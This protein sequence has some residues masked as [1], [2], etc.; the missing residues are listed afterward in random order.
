MHKQ[1]RTLL[2]FAAAVFMFFAAI[3]SVVV[4]VPHLEEDMVEIDVRRM[5]L[6]AIMLGLHFAS[7]A[8]IAFAI[9]VLIAA[10]QSL[11]GLAPA[12][13]YLWVIAVMYVGFGLA[14]FA[15]TRSHHALAYSLMGALVGAAL[16]VPE[17]NKGV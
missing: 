6:R 12:R 17:R 9:I 7:M 4:D 15:V 3:I 16:L 5:L 2:L 1:L 10:V 8:M 13:A 14:A 11:R